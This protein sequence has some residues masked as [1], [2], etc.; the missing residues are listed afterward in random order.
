MAISIARG[1]QYATT[2][3]V[4][5]GN[6]NDLIYRASITGV[7]ASDF[8]SLLTITSYSLPA[9]P[10]VGS[11]A[12]QYEPFKSL[13][14]ASCSDL[15]Y[16]VQGPHGPVAIWGQYG[17]ETRRFYYRGDAAAFLSPGSPFN[18][19]RTGAASVTLATTIGYSTTGVSIKDFVGSCH[20][21]AVSGS[22]PRLTYSGFEDSNVVDGGDTALRHYYYQLN[23]GGL[24]LMQHSPGATSTDGVLGLGLDDSLSGAIIAPWWTFGAPLFRS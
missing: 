23:A 2:D 20:G 4:T 9:A 12:A 13:N 1:H 16:V 19:R 18:L 11:V 10:S 7:V 3:L 17:L 6:L 15:R 8:G 24:G 14:S 21:T 22:Y 5:S